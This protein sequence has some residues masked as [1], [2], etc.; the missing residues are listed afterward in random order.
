MRALAAILL[1]AACGDDGVVVVDAREADAPIDASTRREVN[2]HF[3]DRSPAQGIVVVFHSATGQP[4]QSEITDPDGKVSIDS[5]AIAM[6]TVAAYD[7]ANDVRELNTYVGVPQ[8]ATIHTF[9]GF[10]GASIPPATQIGTLAITFPPNAPAGTNMW[11]FDIQCADTTVGSPTGFEMEVYSYCRRPN[12]NLVDG[13][14]Y[15]LQDDTLVGYVPVLGIDVAATGTTAVDLSGQTWRTDFL[16]YGLTFN[17][18]PAGVTSARPQVTLDVNGSGYSRPSPPSSSVAQGE[19]ITRTFRLP[20]NFGTSLFPATEVYY[21]E[22][23]P[24]GMGLYVRKQALADSDTFDA[25]A[26]LLPR[27]TAA[28]T[29]GRDTVRPSVSWTTAGSEAGADAGVAMMEWPRTSWSIYFPPTTVS[30]L[31]APILPDALAAYRPP[32]DNTVEDAPYVVFYD[33]DYVD[34]YAGALANENLSRPATY[35]ERSTRYPL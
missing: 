22:T 3:A 12:S 7:P 14:A 26:V 1:L 31:Q 34:G 16:D 9:L 24:R 2:V 17:N 30:P 28:A 13:I 25:T 18:M 4:I 33:A 10:G 21:G 19:A 6:I 32:T 11:M 8:D 15:A 5:A 20:R 23:S 27:I 29:T 35:V